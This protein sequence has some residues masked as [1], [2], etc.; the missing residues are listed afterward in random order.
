MPRDGD[1]DDTDYDEN[2]NDLNSQDLVGNL[3]CL[4][5]TKHTFTVSKSKSRKGV[6]AT[7]WSVPHW[8]NE[9]SSIDSN[10]DAGTRKKRRLL[11]FNAHLDP[12]PQCSENRRHQIHEIAAYIRDTLEVIATEDEDADWN[13]TGVLIVGDFNI[14]AGT[15]EYHDVLVSDQ[16]TGWIVRDLFWEEGETPESSL[17][18]HTYAWKNSLAM[19]PDDC[20]RIDYMLAVDQFSTNDNRCY[21][22]MPLKAVGKCI[23]EEPVGEESSDHYALIVDLVPA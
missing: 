11:V 17:H 12:T 3:E 18:Q 13:S 20:G 5:R 9:D 15:H 4:H 6:E 7:L 22:F 8:D 21:N 19:Y 14:Q 1:G 10:S 16:E 2:H 23:R